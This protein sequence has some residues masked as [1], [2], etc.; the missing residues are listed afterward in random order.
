MDD[1]ETFTEKEVLEMIRSSCQKVWDTCVL[2]SLLNEGKINKPSFLLK[3][4]SFKRDLCENI[5][6]FK[7]DRREWV[8]KFRA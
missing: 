5:Y 3:Y 8:R 2:L 4:P 7:R 1:Y 6:K